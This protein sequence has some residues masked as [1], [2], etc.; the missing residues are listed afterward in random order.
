MNDSDIPQPM[1]WLEGAGGE[2]SLLPTD[3]EDRVNALADGLLG[4]ASE[5]AG[6]LL[7]SAAKGDPALDPG[8]GHFVT[9]AAV[10]RFVSYLLHAATPFVVA[11][12]GGR[13]SAYILTAKA[14]LAGDYLPGSRD[15]ST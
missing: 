1:S 9:V 11:Q 10:E 14:P 13:L 5:K 2:L 8:Y 15:S 12:H 3:H 6:R 4:A 7:L